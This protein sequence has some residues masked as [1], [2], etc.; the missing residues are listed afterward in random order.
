M[1]GEGPSTFQWQITGISK[2]KIACLQPAA[3]HVA[4]WF[5]GMVKTS[6]HLRNICHCRLIIWEVPSKPGL[7]LRRFFTV[8]KFTWEIC[9]IVPSKVSN[10]LLLQKK[11]FFSMWCFHYMLLILLRLKTCYLFNEGP[12]KLFNGTIAWL[13]DRIS[14]VPR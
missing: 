13:S 11:V 10:V 8:L 14:V 5:W 12:K 7:F 4:Q 9:C 6:Y 3:D 1:C 2:C